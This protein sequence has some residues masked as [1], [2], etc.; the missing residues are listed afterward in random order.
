[1]P[2]IDDKSNVLLETTTEYYQNT[3]NNSRILLFELDKAILSISR[4]GHHS[5]T[6]N[7]G[8]SIQTVTRENLIDIIKQRDD[9]LYTISMLEERLNIRQAVIHACPGW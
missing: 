3:L 4:G 7:S 8:Q 2:S 5:Y 1:M 9:L 6:I